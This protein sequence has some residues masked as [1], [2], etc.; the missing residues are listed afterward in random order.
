LPTSPFPS[1]SVIKS[2]EPPQHL[3]AYIV[4]KSDLC[5]APSTAHPGVALRQEQPPEEPP[6]ANSPKP[7]GLKG[8]YLTLNLVFGHCSS[9]EKEFS[10]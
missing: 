5:L 1:D 6:G 9:N 7:L 4:R 10:R 2:S 3:H 8:N